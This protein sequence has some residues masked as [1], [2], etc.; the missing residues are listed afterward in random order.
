[1][2]MLECSLSVKPNTHQYKCFLYHS[3]LVVQNNL[4]DLSRQQSGLGSCD[5][6]RFCAR[7]VWWMLRRYDSFMAAVHIGWQ[8]RKR[9]TVPWQCYSWR[10]I[11]ED[12]FLC[13]C[14]CSRGIYMKTPVDFVICNSKC[15]QKEMPT[16]LRLHTTQTNHICYCQVSHLTP[17][18]QYRSSNSRCDVNTPFFLNK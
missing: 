4:P 13:V 1:M 6:C 3:M 15:L 5:L 17:C 18:Y 9:S 8:V 10:E 12:F 7:V 11:E 2:L 16:S 14:V